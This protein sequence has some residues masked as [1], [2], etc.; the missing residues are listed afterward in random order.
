M[1]SQES[2][3]RRGPVIAVLG[4]VLR[5]DEEQRFATELGAA[6]ASQTKFR[7]CVSGFKG[8]QRKNDADVLEPSFAYCVAK[9]AANTLNEQE[10][11][12]RLIT[13]L[14]RARVAAA[15]QF[16]FG[17]VTHGRG[18]NLNSQQ[19]SII[20]DS[21]VVCLGGGGSGTRNIFDF[22][23]G[24]DRPVLPLPFISGK[25]QEL[26]GR[27]HRTLASE[28]GK[29]FKTVHKHQRVELSK[30]SDE[31]LE[32][33][34]S[35]VITA[36]SA[37]TR[38]RCLVFMPFAKHFDWVY[39]R[40]IGVAAEAACAVAIRIDLEHYVGD[41][42]ATFR[43]ELERSDCVIAVVTGENPNVLYEVGYAHAAGK[44]VLLLTQTVGSGAL[45]MDTLFYLQHHRT[46]GYPSQYD[47]AGIARTIEHL[48]GLLSAFR[49]HSVM[50]HS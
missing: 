16:T 5:S 22:A 14:L 23:R 6:I 20:S 34:I 29:A 32:E 36:L 48:C 45:G 31:E 2:L 15:T 38:L 50:G 33:I 10:Q 28:F 35:C 21:D 46:L 42:I 9:G 39:D 1:I 43:Q 25:S 13:K 4:G 8:K 18:R 30:T 41:I 12:D 40:I 37:C 11:S 3:A 19:L 44:P 26:W 47:E 27:Y 24:I 7:V 49:K 17:D